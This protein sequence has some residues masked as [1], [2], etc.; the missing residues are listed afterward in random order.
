VKRAVLYARVSGDDRQNEDRNLLSQLDMCRSYAA[1]RDWQIVAELHEDDQG[2]SGA[3]FEL[4]QLNRIRELARARAFDFLVVCELD[5]LSR[6]LVKQLLFEDE[7]VRQGIKIEYVLG[8][9]PDTVEGNMVKLVKAAIAELERLKIQERIARGSESKV[10]AGSVLLSQSPFGYELVERENRW[11]LAIDEAE[12][13]IVRQMFH[14]YTAGDEGE[15][16]LG[17][18]G[19]HKKLHRLKV[20]SPADMRGAGYFKKRGRGE[21]NR[22]SVVGILSN[23]TY[24][25]TW[26]WRKTIMQNGRCVP[27]PEDGRI[28][29]KVP[30]IISRE[31][32]EAAVAKRSAN[33]SGTRGAT[34]GQH[35]LAKRV[36]CGQ[37]GAR[38]SA[39]LDRREG[40]SPTYYRCPANDK[41]RTQ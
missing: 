23:E 8:E 31:T 26:H 18:Y 35:L 11:T 33:R 14:W 13:E 2:A 3:E 20:P 29:V 19:I 28:A 5:R 21:W 10:R 25:G 38:V 1:E 34:P 27:G 17:T 24:A 4:P 36:V 16:P 37:C 22:C 7:L 32:W 39:R 9:Y 12:A 6:S 41:S 40:D 15:G 30:A